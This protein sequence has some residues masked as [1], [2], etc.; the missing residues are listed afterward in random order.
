MPF[1]F[2][3]TAIEAVVLVESKTFADNRGYF[4][5]GFKRSDFADAGLPI[6]FVQDN[7][8]FSSNSVLRGLHFQRNPYPQGKLV[9]A[10]HGAIF[11]VAVDLRVGSP[12][13]LQWVGEELSEANGRL[14]WV[15]PGFAHGFCVLSESAVVTYKVSGEFSAAHD[16]GVRW[17]DPS[18]GVEWPVIDPVLS[19]KDAAL[20]SLA[21]CEHGFTF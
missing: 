10:P 15:P 19:A 18:I 16:G 8:S 21:D 14:L 3:P 13:Y 5:E 17:N 2:T 4:R 1:T 12:T 6:D 11:D 9:S 20:P 7:V